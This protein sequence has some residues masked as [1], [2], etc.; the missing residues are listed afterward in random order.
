MALYHKYRPK[1]FDDVVGQEHVCTTISN[2][3]KNDKISHAYLFSGPRGIGKTT[4]ARILAKSLNCENIKAGETTPCNKCKTCEEI[5][6]SRSIDVIEMD[7]ATHTQVE[8]IRENVIENAQFRPSKSRYKIFIIDEVHMLS[9]AS[10]NALLKTIEEPPKHVIFVL[11]TTELNKIPETIISRCQRYNFTKVDSDDLKK[12]L[13]EISKKEKVE[14]EEEVLYR[15]VKK[16]EGCVRDALSLLD[17]IF[18][19]NN[20]KISIEDVEL[21]LPNA[22]IEAQIEFLE[23]LLNKDLTASLKFIEKI[24]DEGQNLSFF[25]KSF[26]EFLHLFMIASVDFNL[27]KK[28][29]DLEKNSEEKII[30]LL[31]LINSDGLV[32]LIDLVLKRDSEIKSSPLPQ[33]P[34][35]LLI[36]EWIN[37]SNGQ[38]NTEN[39]TPEIIKEKANKNNIEEKTETPTQNITLEIKETK[40][41]ESATVEE[42]EK[43]ETLCEKVK[44]IVETSKRQVNLEEIKS[45]WD[46]ILKN[47]ETNSPSMVFVLKMANI[48]NVENNVINLEVGFAFHQEKLSEINT[49]IKLENIISEI[50]DEKIKLNICLNENCKEIKVNEELQNLASALGGEIV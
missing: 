3:I 46:E 9:T 26:I 19:I 34:L 29:I 27:A 42:T 50:L 43:K 24:V 28:A 1:T 5:D 30:K 22:N 15:I 4:I 2:Q 48:I 47:I 7:A 39:Q 8:N 6:S 36:L 31:K 49:K 18:A 41:E 11:A 35:E 25:S 10:F 44:K 38:K 40:I 37:I 16:S 21:L 12:Y 32:K 13:K 45:K 33:L 17:Q 14:I 23:N 20:K